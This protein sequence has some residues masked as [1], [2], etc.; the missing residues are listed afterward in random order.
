MKKTAIVSILFSA[1]AFTLYQANEEKPVGYLVD[2]Q[3]GSDGKF[4][5]FATMK[6]DT[7]GKLSAGGIHLY[8]YEGGGM[9]GYL[10]NERV[11]PVNGEGSL[12]PKML[13][14]NKGQWVYFNNTGDVDSII[15]FKR[16]NGYLVQLDSGFA[17]NGNLL[18]IDSL[19]KVSYDKEVIFKK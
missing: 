12:K 6:K 16:V 17:E 10:S 1:F 18:Y 14:I 5:G 4:Q 13:I 19:W 9:Y 11:G 8:K 3:T 2:I 15:D 7:H